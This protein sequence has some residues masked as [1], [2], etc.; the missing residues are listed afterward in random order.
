MITRLQKFIYQEFVNRMRNSRYKGGSPTAN[1]NFHPFFSEVDHLVCQNFFSEYK[2]RVNVQ[3]TK[4]QD[5]NE[6]TKGNW[7]VETESR[8]CENCHIVLH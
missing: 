6:N 3:D 5:V 1:G 8:I 7:S 2:M 4:I